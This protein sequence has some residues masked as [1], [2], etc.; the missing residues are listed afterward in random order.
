MSN[1][2]DFR[3][4]EQ[5]SG[6]KGID[7]IQDIFDILISDLTVYLKVNPINKNVKIQLI[8][9]DNNEEKSSSH[10][11]DFGIIRRNLEDS[12]TIDL[13]QNY[14][15]FLPFIILREVYYCFIPEEAKNNEIVKICINQIIENDL[16]KFPEYKKWYELIRNE[17]VNRD[18]LIAQF[19]RLKKY[20]K[21]DSAIQTENPVQ[22]FI[23]YIR[24]NTS[25]ISG[26]NI[27]TF[28]D[29]I[30]EDYTYKSS[31]SFY[32]EEMIETLQKLIK[33]FYYKEEYL[34]LNDYQDLFKQ[35]LDT[36]IIESN[37]SLRKFYEN[38]Q[39]INR[40]TPIA[41]SYNIVYTAINVYPVV[42]F[43]TFNPL[44]ERYKIKKILTV[45]PFFQSLKFAE[46]HFSGRIS[47]I[48]L[49]PKA[50]LTDLLRYF[51]KLETF[52]YILANSIFLMKNSNNFLNL[53]Y[54]SSST[55]NKIIDPSLKD[56][57]K[58]YEIVHSYEFPFN[59][60][61]KP[62]SIFD[63]TLLDRIVNYSV[64]GLTF[65]K[66][67]ETVNAIKEDVI[68]EYRKQIA[69][70]ED[71]RDY[72]E[73]L[74]KSESPKVK[75]WFI[76]YLKGNIHKGFFYIHELFDSL[77][78]Y[79]ESIHTI[80]T[81]AKVKN[82]HDL[83]NILITQKS[84]YG[85]EDNLIIDDEKLER[86]VF[87][88]IFPN[89]QNLLNPQSIDGEIEKFKV[90]SRIFY[91]CYNLKILD[92]KSIIKILE[93][94]DYV[95]K[96]N[97]AKE[98]KLKKSFKL[99][100]SSTITNPKIESTIREFLYDPP[101]L[102]IPL[103]INTI[104]TS[105]FAKYYPI[106]ILKHS[107]DIQKKLKKLISYFP[108]A[109]FNDFI[110]TNTK[111]RYIY[112]QIYVANIKEKK[113]FISSIYSIFKNSIVLINRWFWR[114]VSRWAKT[115]AKEFYDFQNNEFFYT[116]ELFNQLFIYTQQVFGSKELEHYKMKGEPVNPYFFWSQNQN[117]ASLVNNIKKRISHQ[118]LDFSS[119]KVN[120][121]V[122][123]RN[124]LEEIIQDQEVFK[125]IKTT[126]FFNTYIKSMRFLPAFRKFG[127]AQYNLYLCPFN[128]NEIDYKLLF[129]NSFQE[130]KYP[131]EI[132]PQIPLHINYLFPYRTPNKAYLN[133]IIRSK[134]IIREYCFFFIKKIYEILHFNHSLSA[135]GWQYSSKRFKIH[136]QNILFNP[137][138]T[139]KIP[140]LR[141]FNFD[142]YSP[143]GVYGHSSSEFQALSQI[144]DRKSI[145]AKSYLGT[146]KYNV[147]DKIVNLLKKKL[148]F[149]YISLKNLNL[150]DKVSIILPNIKPNSKE[151]IIKIFSYFNLCR[152]FEIE[153][154]FFLYGFNDIDSFEEGL[155]IEIRFPKCELDEFFEIFDLL[156]QYLEIKHYLISSD[157]VKNDI[158]LRSI[159][160]NLNFLNSYNPLIN[161]RWNNK[162][163]IWMNHKLFSKKF[164]P[165]YPDLTYGRMP[166]KIKNHENDINDDTK[167]SQQSD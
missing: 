125:N 154:E 28:Y 123:F 69:I 107:P 52:G 81:T 163:K 110:D 6:G 10:I 113:E 104:T 24:N 135:S 166:D 70:I 126:D 7:Q 29:E 63:Y 18:F 80:L 83:K 49:I 50:Y 73:T 115:S 148:I 53:N 151:K 51:K 54:F 165:I 21:I 57:K 2:L 33:I 160:K 82:K 131:A 64:T 162:D 133:W 61:I 114:G 22:H 101:H 17:L 93:K 117:I 128:W 109:F 136:M 155:F 65:D 3:I 13:S 26:Y 129:T 77:V 94:P 96:I 66:R 91:S 139:Y 147:I 153:G 141:E 97:K 60:L 144:Y 130:I 84:Y 39:W 31:K 124:K 100:R 119:Y 19:D 35:S 4:L 62:L 146:N 92:L 74:Q 108:R 11:L 58:E 145:D 47:L 121:L 138:Y 46:N 59:S 27:N 32:N 5:L 132:T 85:I 9:E 103:L 89:S 137:T 30:F 159:Y 95:K 68:N 12:L 161:L 76:E 37:L 1:N 40:S 156:F 86:I 143:T 8:S 48:F 42:C 99:S 111:E 120:K 118:Q 122:E 112:L 116:K 149:P 142:D 79:L 140:N 56:Y 167:S 45:L 158:F 23:S 152:I 71:F 67:I 90:Y 36:G 88:E 44:I 25:I 87:N 38:L 150:Q 20:F 14:T 75:E 15:N 134:R 43:L 106:V 16:E 41:P 78:T 72:F 157:L 55:R 105:D 127:L 164:E 98:Q 102:I 34:N